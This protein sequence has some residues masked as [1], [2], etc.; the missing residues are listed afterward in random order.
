MAPSFPTTR[1]SL[2]AGSAGDDARTAW[3]ELAR[4]YRGPIEAYFRAR[5]GANRAEDL[6]QAFFAAS[7]DGA[8]WARA[9]AGQG[10][11][12]TYLRM[13]LGRFG[14]RHAAML[15]SSK[16]AVEPDTLAGDEGPDAAYE[17]QFAHVLVARALARLDADLDAADRALLPFL[18][19]RGDPGDLK[20][21]AATTG[22]SAD[23][24]RQRLHRL[25]ARLR[26][27]LHAE[28]ADLAA[29]ATDVDAELRQIHA[30]IAPR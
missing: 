29:G 1:W 30:A 7:I 2:I 20:Q 27:A 11:F 14:A 4:A 26:A 6:T 23:A 12:R 8:W 19:E 21:L 5:F 18:L 22:M 9:D 15:D 28:V 17:R 13:L 16:A 10:G 3:S 24:L 25:R